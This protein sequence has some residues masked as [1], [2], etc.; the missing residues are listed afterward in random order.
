MIG[1]AFGRAGKW[2][3]T[4]LYATE[5]SRHFRPVRSQN[6][7]YR[8]IRLTMKDSH[9]TPLLEE[10]HWED[11]WHAVQSAMAEACFSTSS[12]TWPIS[13]QS[14]AWTLNSHNGSG[15][16]AGSITWNANRRISSLVGFT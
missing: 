1:E 11:R 10:L 12:P 8:H 4:W 14:M 6:R 16:T 9:V 15:N 3:E 2:L 13:L 5:L 7:T